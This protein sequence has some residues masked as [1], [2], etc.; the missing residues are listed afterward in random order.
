MER[1]PIPPLTDVVP[2]HAPQ[3]G[4]A[5]ALLAVTGTAARIEGKFEIANSIEIECEVAGELRVGG[6][7]VIG[8]NGR[9]NA[10]VHTVDALILGSYAGNLVATGS[11]EIASTG[12]VSGNVETPEFIIAKGGV[13][14][15]NVTR[16]AKQADDPLQT[17]SIAP[18]TPGVLAIP[19]EAAQ[20]ATP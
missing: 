20:V 8:Q 10:D 19:L 17:L 18:P 4:E 12:R 11:I 3:Q 13:F 9:V 2:R 6:K 16:P 14:T 15:G 7:L 5:T 1:H